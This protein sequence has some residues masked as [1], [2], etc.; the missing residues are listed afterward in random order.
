KEKVDAAYRRRILEL[1]LRA[2]PLF[3]DLDARLL[4]RLRPQIELEEFQPGDLILD[5]HDQAKSMYIIRAGFVK[6]MKGSSV[7]MSQASVGDWAQLCKALM[8][9]GQ[10]ANS[11]QA[12]IWALLSQK[13]AVIEQIAAG[14]VAMTEQRQGIVYALN[15]LLKQPKLYSQIGAELLAEA[16]PWKDEAKVL[17]ASPRKWSQHQKVR[18]FNRRLLAVLYPG[19]IPPHAGGPVRIL[20]YRSENDPLI[21]EAALILNEPRT[22]TCV[23]Y[24]HYGE[25]KEINGRVET[26][27]ISRAL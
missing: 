18:E 17:P 22:A 20:A 11:P 6:V 16:A 7:L 19:A 12:K 25:G 21:G 27:R 9:G 1:P 13:H 14:Q 23:A 15:E 10:Q 5:E 4:D 26:L 2:A 8:T 3:R 24:D